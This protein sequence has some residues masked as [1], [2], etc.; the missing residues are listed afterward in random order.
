M[1]DFGA[2]PKDTVECLALAKTTKPQPQPQPQPQGGGGELHAHP[3]IAC[4]TIGG[5][6][7][8]GQPWEPYHWGGGTIIFLDFIPPPTTPFSVFI[9]NMFYLKVF[10]RKRNIFDGQDADDSRVETPNDEGPGEAGR[11]EKN[12]DGQNLSGD[13][14]GL[15]DDCE[16]NCR[17]RVVQFDL[18]NFFDEV[19]DQ[20]EEEEKDEEDNW[21]DN[22]KRRFENVGERR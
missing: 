20:I 10:N 15:S 8:A 13:R 14:N 12:S 19:S 16:K 7:G 22:P 3:G 2:P 1:D 9:F 6:G 11:N 17:R 4:M 21:E 18:F 5:G